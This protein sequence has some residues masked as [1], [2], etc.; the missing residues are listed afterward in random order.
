MF[1]W[2]KKKTNGP[3][4]SAIDSQEKVEELFRQGVLGKAYLM[5]LEFG[6]Q[7]FPPN[8]VFVPAFAA[9]LKA[10]NDMNIVMPL[11]QVGKVKHYDATPEYQGNSFVPIAIK[12]TAYDPGH[13]SCDI[14][15]WG[16]ALSRE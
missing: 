7:D 8:W 1:G 15:I 4:F 11:V 16:A 13:F 3:D 12:V 10:H 2:F 9:Q 5:P 6:G 14:K